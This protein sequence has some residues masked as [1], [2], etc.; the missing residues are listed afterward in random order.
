MLIASAQSLAA[1]VLF[2]LAV[3]LIAVRFT[4]RQNRALAAVLLILGMDILMRVI[5]FV[6]AHPTF[7]AN[8]ELVISPTRVD[9]YWDR[10]DTHFLL[11]IPPVLAYFGV[12]YRN[13]VRPWLRRT[14]AI[15]IVVAGAAIQVLYTADVCLEIC[16]KDG[17]NYYGPLNA[18]AAGVPMAFA[19]TAL[20]LAQDKT[21]PRQEPGSRLM[22][23]G[24]ACF[25]IVQ[26]MIFLLR[27]LIAE[28]PLLPAPSWS[29]ASYALIHGALILGLAVVFLLWRQ[30]TAQKRI[31]TAGG[32]A[33][34]TGALAGYGV[35]G[36]LHWVGELIAG[37]WRLAL[38]CMLTFALL[39]FRVFGIE[40]GVKRGIARTAVVL[41]FLM[42]FFVVKTVTELYLGHTYG[43]L[44]GGV[45]AG[46][47]LLILHPLE[48][49]GNRLA[50]FLMPHA[51]PIHGLAPSE[52]ARMYHDFA[53]VAW[54]DGKMDRKEQGALLT[55]RN[56]L[57]LSAQEAEVLELRARVETMERKSLD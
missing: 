14:L 24:L 46:G 15:T 6:T 57:G 30:G 33:I 5:K 48:H 54:E 52:R 47:A 36:G 37:L 8:G 31:A 49:M 53:A 12:V 44:W 23:L 7:G 2:T 25:A 39:R 34:I 20:A 13:E 22:A 3:I 55:M 26:G 28:A 11:A 19:A 35:A 21:H 41:V 45:A 9:S 17:T 56:R 1:F 32:V 29:T 40:I 42:V 4:S 38:A 43:Y 50:D 27:L 18:V 51:Q 10:M 16:V